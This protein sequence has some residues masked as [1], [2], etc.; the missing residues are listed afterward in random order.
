MKTKTILTIALAS[1]IV[2][3]CHAQKVQTFGQRWFEDFKQTS[4]E[5]QEE[6]KQ[7]NCAD[8]IIQKEITIYDTT[9]DYHRKWWALR[10][11][12]EISCD[13]T[14][15]FLLQT[16]I[17]DSSLEFRMLALQYLVWV[18]AQNAI[19]TLLERAKAD[20]PDEEK[21]RIGRTI[22]LLEDERA[23]PIINEVC[24]RS[25]NSTICDECLFNVYDHTPRKES[26]K[27]YL[28]RM[29]NTKNEKEQVEIANRLAMK[30]CYRKAIPVLRKM[31]YSKD[32]DTRIRAAWGLGFIDNTVSLNLLQAL[33]KDTGNKNLKKEI[34][35]AYERIDYH[36]SLKA[37]KRNRSKIQKIS[38][39]ATAENIVSPST[40]SASQ[41]NE[42]NFDHAAAVAYAK[43]WC[44]RFNPAYTNY[45]NAGGDCA[46]F[47]SQCLIAGGLDLS[48]G[49]DGKGLGVTN[50][51]VIANVDYLVQ[52]LRDIQK[53][54]HKELPESESEP[55]FVKE[56]DPVF[57]YAPLQSIRHSLLCIRDLGENT[58]AC[59]SSSSNCQSYR[60]NWIYE[61]Q[62]LNSHFFHIGERIYPEHCYNCVHDVD[63]GE[64]DMDCGGPCKPCADAPKTMSIDNSVLANQNWYVASEQI[65]TEGEISFQNREVPY[66]LIAG[67]EVILNEGF[68][69]ESDA[70]FSVQIDPDPVN[71][72]REFSHI[73]QR[74]P[75][76]I[77]PNGDG[78]N[79]VWTVTLVGYTHMSIEIKEP[80][81]NKVIFG[82]KNPIDR[83]GKIPI[84]NGFYKG[85]R[86][87]SHNAYGWGMDLIDYNG[88]KHSFS[89]MISVLYDD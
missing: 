85:E 10:T 73:C 20:L 16:A 76:V 47:V 8:S 77:T 11:L 49:A 29:K 56:G 36:Q 62:K 34:K 23:V 82:Y 33:A 75:D 13:K 46:A 54:Q 72:V 78:V 84:W 60:K 17:F 12:G 86:V 25:S 69:V 63:K 24:Y 59:H 32:S 57:F 80:K 19:P 42:I 68:S 1:F 65:A 58:Y 35:T 28:Y 3:V 2:M 6:R 41:Q 89:G 22:M 51:R 64:I 31:A 27:Y 52:H 66:E 39:D 9:T 7:R 48:K 14:Q 30:D 26:I 44:D 15:N 61:Y 55:D 43:Q 81:Y 79:D 4:K 88:K 21:L 5:W 37:A 74:F 67:E 45:S 87:P 18:D 38:T 50:D 70:A 83:D 71:F 40:S 53:F